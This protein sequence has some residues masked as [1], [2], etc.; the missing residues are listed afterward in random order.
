VATVYGLVQGYED[1]NDHEQLRHD[2]FADVC[3]KIM[4]NGDEELR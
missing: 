2:L 1:L 4:G 3:R